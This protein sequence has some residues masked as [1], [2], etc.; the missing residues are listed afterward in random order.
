[1]FNLS[2]DVKNTIKLALIAVTLIACFYGGKFLQSRDKAL[3]IYR[4]A[5]EDF[6]NKNY[7]NSYYLFSR[8]NPMSKIK[9]AALYRQA[10]CARILDDTNS[11]E[12]AYKT[13]ISRYPS[14]ELTVEAKYRLGQILINKNPKDAKK[15]F[16]SVIKSHP[17]R[18][19]EIASEYYLAKIEAAE[20]PENKAE[21]ENKFRQYLTQ[22]PDGRLAS[23]VVKSWREFNPEIKPDDLMLIAKSYY[24]SGNYNETEKILSNTDLTKSWAIQGVNYLKKG[25]NQKGKSI[26][27][28]GISENGDKVDKSDYNNA[29]DEYIKTEQNYYQTSSFL[30]NKAKGKHKEYIWNIKCKYSPKSTKLACYEQLY[31]NFPKG[32]FAQSAMENIILGRILNKN[33]GGAKTVADDYILKYPESEN[34]DMVMF[35]RAKIEQKYSHNPQF[36]IL[37]R[38]VINN[39]PDSYYAYRAFWITKSLNNAVIQTELDVKPVEYPYKYPAKNSLLYNLIIVQ[40]YDLIKKITDDEF[41]KSWA[42]YKQGNYMTSVYTAQKAMEKI[43]NK[44][45]KT[46]VRWRL[47]YPMN[48]YKQIKNNTS[49]YNNDLALIMALIR[50][51]SHFNTY[52]QSG[53]GAIGLMQLMPSTAHDVG[54]NYGISFNTTDLFNPELNI[55]L[56]NIYY[57]SLK[58]MAKN[59]DLS[60]VAGYNGGIGSVQRWKNTLSYS[61]TDEFVEQIPYDE[62]RNYVK[63]VF[64]SYW[65]YVRIYQH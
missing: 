45:P 6:R 10:Q 48:Y 1:M 42:E 5:L 18:D 2:E 20:V 7:S 11:E 65:N 13:L 44:P 61:D 14:N 52:A 43:K 8:I 27:L 17:K 60:A 25:Q 29:I 26:I 49:D 56:G 30:L 63:K 46:D 40:D 33:Y 24:K 19:Y 22:Y 51:E 41:I 12:L 37:Y 59:M 36:D 3:N 53:V 55:K 35:W 39:F 38:N 64:R 57:S 58:K 31:A 54:I 4:A 15:F 9:P 32:Q 28:D 50:E 47:V 62:T 16:K 34:I 23:E 21:T